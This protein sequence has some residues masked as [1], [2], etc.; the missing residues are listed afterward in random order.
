MRLLQQTLQRMIMGIVRFSLH[1]WHTKMTD[2]MFSHYEKKIQ[3]SRMS[4]ALRIV[5]SLYNQVAKIR[6]SKAIHAWFRT[7]S[8]HNM[9]QQLEESEAAAGEKLSQFTAAA[10]A[11][12]A[13][14][15][16]KLQQHAM[17][18]GM[19]VLLRLSRRAALAA[20]GAVYRQWR[21][22]AIRDSSTNAAVQIGVL[23][24]LRLLM[25]AANTNRRLTSLHFWSWYMASINADYKSQLGFYS[26]SFQE[27]AA[28]VSGSAAMKTLRRIV[29]EIMKGELGLRLFLWRRNIQLDVEKKYAE[30]M[31][32]Y[33][34][35]SRH[36]STLFRK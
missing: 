8:V 11:M 14:L 7:A 32:K 12:Q 28:K 18:M 1:C 17:K 27:K 30:M 9:T 19:R 23:R 36:F 25:S 33:E 10:L 2:E 15:D 26:E 34:A 22:N 16:R 29:V 35:Q 4:L 20:P 31:A 6:L 13:R 24:R 21:R 3:S 5:L